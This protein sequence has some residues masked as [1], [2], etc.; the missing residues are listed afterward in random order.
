VPVLDPRDIPSNAHHWYLSGPISGDTKGNIAKF[1]D[2]S[3]ELRAR[4]YKI[5]CPTEVCDIDKDPSLVGK[6]WD[7]FMRRD[8]EA[9]M[10]DHVGGIILL[11][12]WEQSR[13]ARVELNLARSLNYVIAEFKQ[14]LLRGASAQTA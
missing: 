12:G 10:A 9:L 6:T 11:P 5:L 7:W 2:A 13:G 4:G 14:F 8:I 3:A 1:R